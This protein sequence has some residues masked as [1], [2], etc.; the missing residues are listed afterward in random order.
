MKHLIKKSSVWIIVAIWALS[1]IMSALFVWLET[2]HCSNGDEIQLDEGMSKCGYLVAKYGNPL[3]STIGMNVCEAETSGDFDYDYDLYDDYAI[4]STH[5]STIVLSVAVLF[6]VV[7]TLI[8]PVSYFLIVKRVKNSAHLTG[9]FQP[10]E[11]VNKLVTMVMV[12]IAVF[13]VCWAP[14]FMVVIY[15]KVT[16]ETINAEL[17]QIT[18]CLPYISSLCNPFIYSIFSAKFKES[19]I[20]VFPLQK[21]ENYLLKSVVTDMSNI[22]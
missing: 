11:R 19:L 8:I 2:A 14:F 5:E 4:Q 17:Y 10:D 1:S 21:R 15:E 6:L 13:I 9:R 18:S 16:D 20:R 12:I 7:P 22:Q 3:G